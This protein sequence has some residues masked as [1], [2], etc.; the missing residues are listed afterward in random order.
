M[1]NVAEPFWSILFKY[2][3]VAYS[4]CLV[5]CCKVVVEANKVRRTHSGKIKH[6]K[7]LSSS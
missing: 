6:F 1:L 7:K 3:L 2:S 5:K 4:K